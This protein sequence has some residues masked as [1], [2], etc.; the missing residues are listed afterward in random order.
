MGTQRDSG[1]D[2]SPRNVADRLKEESKQRIERGKATAADQIDNV[3]NAL[4][5][6]SRQLGGSSTL[7][8]YTDRLAHNIESFGSRLRHGSI[9][10]IVGDIQ[11]AARRNPALFVAGGLALGVVLARL[12]R[13]AAQDTEAYDVE[14][15]EYDEF[16]TGSSPAGDIS[17][18]GDFGTTPDPTRRTFGG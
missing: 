13:A 5:S 3:A 11:A 12:V 8:S 1:S 18:S 16:A 2:L 14:Y 15:T 4:K 6:A 10:E 9:D 7:G 17:E